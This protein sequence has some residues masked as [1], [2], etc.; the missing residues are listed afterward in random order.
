MGTKKKDKLNW[1]FP[2]DL[3]NTDLEELGDKK[4]QRMNV[5][6]SRVQEKMVFVLS[7]KPDEFIC[8]SSFKM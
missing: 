8:T 3:S 1:I 5:G 2:T 4:A 7:K 6:L